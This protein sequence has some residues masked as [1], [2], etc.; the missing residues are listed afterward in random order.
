MDTAATNAAPSAAA[1]PDSAKLDAFM[2]RMLG[3]MGAAMNAAAVLVGGRLGLWRALAEGGPTDSVGLAGRT[4][5]AERAVRE[6]LAA[7]AASGYLDHDPRTDRYTLPPEQ[8]MVFAD[9]ASPVYLMGFFDIAAAAWRDEPRITESFRHGRGVGWHERDRCLFC[10]TESFFRTSYNHQLVQ[11]WL[12]ALEGVV[13]KLERG[14]LVADVGCG[15]GA[16]TIIMA[17]AF[18][19]SQFVGF[20]YHAASFAAAREAAERAG[21]ADRATFEV[22]SAKQVPERGFGL[23][24]CFDCLHDMGDPV[25]AAAHLRRTLAPDGT[26]MI[27]EPLARDRLADNMN[28]VGRIYYAAST[29]V[30]TPAS[31]AQEVGAALG[32]QAGPA[33]LEAVVREGGFGRMRVAVETPFNMVLEARP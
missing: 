31:M 29:M 2:G 11:S 13:E 22:A 14:A 5:T 9:E 32:A 27:V 4:G 23:V 8:A 19:N 6:W 21:V 30:C 7:Q 16:S 12:P 10:G 24:C 25:G 18:P 20:D 17:R 1:A 28:P 15:H 33:R 3:D 26:W